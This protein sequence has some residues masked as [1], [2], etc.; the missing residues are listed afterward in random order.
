[1]ECRLERF[2][3]R[4]N[5]LIEKET[6]KFNELEHVLIE[7]CRSTFSEHALAKP[8]CRRL[9]SL[10]LLPDTLEG[11]TNGAKEQSA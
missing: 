6:L 8:F 4:W 3:I 2:S 9:N 1:M 5:H 10:T 11:L 7:K